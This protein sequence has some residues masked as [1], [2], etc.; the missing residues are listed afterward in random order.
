MLYATF[1]LAVRN[2]LLHKL[3]SVLT[4]LGTILGVASVIAMLSIGEGSKQ[5]ALEQIR[6]LGAANV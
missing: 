6:R 2:L 1:R 5:E 3:R 4:L